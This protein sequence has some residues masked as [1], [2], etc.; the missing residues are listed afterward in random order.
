MY[1]PSYTQAVLVEAREYLVQSHHVPS[2]LVDAAL[3]QLRLCEEERKELKRQLDGLESGER[4]ILPHTVEHARHLYQVALVCLRSNG[5][6]PEQEKGPP[7]GGPLK[8]AGAR[9]H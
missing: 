5:A 3:A 1:D 6:D 4:V 8:S 2:H 9:D 7:R